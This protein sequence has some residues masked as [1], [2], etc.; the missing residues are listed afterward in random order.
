MNNGQQQH[1]A[2]SEAPSSIRSE[3]L[4]SRSVRVHWMFVPMDPSGRSFEGFYIGFREILPLLPDQKSSSMAGNLLSVNLSRIASSSLVPS[5]L[6]SSLS[7]SSSQQQQQFRS[8]YSFKTIE[9]SH[10]TFPMKSDFHIVLNELRRN[11]RYGI[12][13][14]AFNRKGSGPASE[15]ILIQTAEFG[16]SLRF[17]N[18][19]RV[20]R[21]LLRF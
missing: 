16:T 17:C 6:S 20:R 9:L 18:V 7:S 10:K 15:E 1:T 21:R 5:S 13:V 14:Q 11:T 4:S 8:M 19:R 2:P 3:V 12:I